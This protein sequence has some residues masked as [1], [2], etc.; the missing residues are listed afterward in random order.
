MGA[1]GEGAVV[2]RAVITSQVAALIYVHE[3]ARDPAIG[4][5]TQPTPPFSPSTLD[6]RA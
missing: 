6:G 1:V 3:G 2:R 4:A 5:S